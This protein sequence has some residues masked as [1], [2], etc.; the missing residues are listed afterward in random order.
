MNPLKVVVRMKKV[1]MVKGSTLENNT[2]EIS[3]SERQSYPKLEELKI[4]VKE[5]NM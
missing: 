5:K 1:R 4:V 3:T 2:G